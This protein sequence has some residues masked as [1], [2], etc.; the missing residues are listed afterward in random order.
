[1]SAAPP[2]AYK[3]H[4]AAIAAFKNVWPPRAS[5]FAEYTVIGLLQRIRA[6]VCTAAKMEIARP[7]PH[8]LLGVYAIF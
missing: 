2:K 4:P 5:D 3:Q 7:G 6:P 8:K 1:M